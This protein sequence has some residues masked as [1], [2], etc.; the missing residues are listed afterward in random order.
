MITHKQ[1][2]EEQLCRSQAVIGFG[3]ETAKVYVQAWW[4]SQV[5]GSVSVPLGPQQWG[6]SSE[7]RATASLLMSLLLSGGDVPI[8][9]KIMQSR[10]VLL[11]KAIAV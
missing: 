6:C 3:R 11:I 4:Q 8:V 10:I 7:P 9:P 2:E 1:P 5:P